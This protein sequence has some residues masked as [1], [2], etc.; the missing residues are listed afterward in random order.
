M[1]A[2]KSPGA[3]GEDASKMAVTIGPARPPQLESPLQ[4]C[5]GG[6]GGGREAGDFDQRER[7]GSLSLVEFE[8]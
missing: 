6:Q 4:R 1:P 3:I 7:V 2:R 8:S 5:T